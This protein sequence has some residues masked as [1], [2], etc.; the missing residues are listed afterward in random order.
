[1]AGLGSRRVLVQLLSARQAPTRTDSIRNVLK[2]RLAHDA[3]LLSSL[4]SPC[5]VV[6]HE[7]LYLSQSML[8]QWRI[9]LLVPSSNTTMETEL[10]A[11]FRAREQVRPEEQFTLH[12]ARMRM[13]HV[14]P[15]ELRRMNAETARATREL[16]DARVDLV[17]TACLVA[18]MSQGVGHHHTAETEIREVLLECEQDIPVV[19]S[20]GALVEGL[21]AMG[22]RRISM[23][24][25]YMQ[26]LTTLVVEYVEDA[27]IDVC[28]TISLEVSDNIVV[29]RLDPRDLRQHWRQ[30]ELDGCDALV[31]SACVQMP[32]LNVVEEI[33]DAA[34]VPVVTA[35]TTTAWGILSALGLE[36]VAPGGGALL[37]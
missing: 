9:G 29:G 19:S 34:G 31:L 10:P 23:I 27:G 18:I 5:P 21:R 6:D 4:P 24:T 12:S 2:V 30:L 1:V 36:P 37:A 22:A 28:D 17:A 35:A 25:P 3:D 15:E 11:L 7:A 20:A 8:R 33:E 14:T 26:P 16:A 13:E 32:S